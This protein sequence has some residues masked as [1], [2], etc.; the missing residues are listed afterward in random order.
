[1]TKGI[2]SRIWHFIWDEDSVWSWVI[3]VVL[4]FAVIKWLLYPAL[5]LLLGT[6]V[7]IVAVVSGSMEHTGNLEAYWNN[8]ICCD[9]K[10]MFKGIPGE[11]YK[12]VNISRED[13][14][15]FDFA[16]GFNKGDIMIL[17]GADTVE[18]GEVLVYLTSKPDPIIHRVI[19]IQTQNS[20]NIF[21]TK[22]DNNCES[23]DFEQAIPSANVLGK[24]AWRIP[25]LGWVKIF[26]V[27]LLNLAR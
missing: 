12:D 20:N 19:D 13:F 6:T 17:T 15:R 4:A 16:N 26:A 27:D 3:N 2:L 10:C 8:P 9:E 23:G 21:K 18:Q 22:G 25:F 24:A 11:Y 14:R 1:M 5:G 7:P